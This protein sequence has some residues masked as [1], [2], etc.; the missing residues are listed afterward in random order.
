MSKNINAVTED[1]INK[2]CKCHIF[3][4]EESIRLIPFFFFWLRKKKFR[5]KEMISW[6]FSKQHS[7]YRIESSAVEMNQNV[8]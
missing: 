7:T 4:G 8:K 2:E 5:L 3:E 6:E 1:R